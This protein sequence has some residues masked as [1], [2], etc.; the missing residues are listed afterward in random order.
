MKT[1]SVLVKQEILVTL[2]EAKFTPQFFAA[3][4][5]SFFPLETV[6]DHAEHLGQLAARGLIDDLPD[7]FVEGYGP[8]NEMGI[9]FKE[10]E[11]S[12]SVEPVDGD[13]A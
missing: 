5:A 4:T 2:D 9:S 12:I 3:F 6:E 8:I 7:T 13:E 1:F 10:G 11:M